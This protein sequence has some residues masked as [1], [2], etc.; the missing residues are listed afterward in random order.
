MPA[1]DAPAI[2]RLY[3]YHV[4]LMTLITSLIVTMLDAADTLRRRYA[5]VR[6][7]RRRQC[8]AL[9]ERCV[10]DVTI[11]ARYVS[12]AHGERLLRLLRYAIKIDHT[13]LWMPRHRFTRACYSY[14]ARVT[15]LR[16]RR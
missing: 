6:A 14:A 15:L 12:D 10:R 9:S 3:A 11:C 1:A 13:A 8:V 4:Y 16:W 7:D 5:R 2:I